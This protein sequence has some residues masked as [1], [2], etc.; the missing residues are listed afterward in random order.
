MEMNQ[1]KIHDDLLKRCFPLS[2]KAKKLEKEPYNNSLISRMIP[3]LMK[4]SSPGQADSAIEELPSLEM[5]NELCEKVLQQGRQCDVKVLKDLLIQCHQFR[6]SKSFKA[7]LASVPN[8]S[9]LFKTIQKLGR[10]RVAN[11]AIID[12]VRARPYQFFHVDV[13][14]VPKISFHEINVNI[15]P[16]ADLLGYLRSILSTWRI[17]TLSKDTFGK[18]GKKFREK[19]VEPPAVHAEMQLVKFYEENPQIPQPTIMG[20]SKK[21]CYLCGAFLRIQ[22]VFSVQRTSQKLDNQWTMPNIKC[23]NAENAVTYNNSLEKMTVELE[24]SLRTTV[25]LGPNKR[26]MRE[27]SHNLLTFA[28]PK[29]LVP[30]NSGAVTVLTTPK[31]KDIDE[32]SELFEPTPPPTLPSIFLQR[33]NA[34]G[35]FGNFSL[36]HFVRPNYGPN[37][38]SP[39]PSL[40]HYQFSPHGSLREAFRQHRARLNTQQEN[41]PGNGL[42]S[43]RP[44]EH[45]SSNNLLHPT[46]PSDPLTPPPEPESEVEYSEDEWYREDYNFDGYKFDDL[47]SLLDREEYMSRITQNIHLASH[48]DGHTTAAPSSLD[49]PETTSYHGTTTTSAYTYSRSGARPDSLTIPN[50]SLLDVYAPP[51]PQ[52][53]QDEKDQDSLQPPNSPLLPAASNRFTVLEN[54][55]APTPPPVQSR[56]HRRSRHPISTSVTTSS[57]SPLPSWE[58]YDQDQDYTR[59][60]SRSSHTVYSQ[61]ESQ[62]ENLKGGQVGASSQDQFEN[63]QSS[64][65]RRSD[66][67]NDNGVTLLEAEVDSVIQSIKASTSEQRPLKRKKTSPDT[68]TFVL[69]TKSEISSDG[70]GS[71][72]VPEQ[73]G[74]DEQQTYITLEVDEELLRAKP[75]TRRRR[76][77]ADEKRKERERDDEALSRS[78]CSTSIHPPSSSLLKTHPSSNSAS[79]AGHKDIKHQSG[80]WLA[81]SFDEIPTVTPLPKSMLS[82]LPKLSPSPLSPSAWLASSYSSKQGH[83]QRQRHTSPPH[84]PSPSSPLNPSAATQHLPSTGPRK[85]KKRNCSYPSSRSQAQAHEKTQSQPQSKLKRKKQPPPPITITNHSSATTTR[86]NGSLHTRSRIPMTTTRRPSILSSPSIPPSPTRTPKRVNFESEIDITSYTSTS[87]SRSNSKPTRATSNPNSKPTTKDRSWYPH[88]HDHYHHNTPL[89]RT[90]SLLNNESSETREG[91][92]HEGGGG[93]KLTAQL[94]PTRTR[95]EIAYAESAFS[96][97]A[98]PHPPAS[99]TLSS[100]STSA[101]TS[102]KPP[103]PSALTSAYTHTHAHTQLSQRERKLRRTSTSST[104]ITSSNGGGKEAHGVVFR[105]DYLT[106]ETTGEQVLV[107]DIDFRRAVLRLRVYWGG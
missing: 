98:H 103:A 7:F 12:A 86:N 6:R 59:T 105:V 49:Y 38:P 90:R 63:K 96:P 106:E 62:T 73:S 23:R 37:I 31:E 45:I 24:D 40:R 17:K 13:Q 15:Y 14:A 47:E 74:G 84:P 28:A 83:R 30:K 65:H 51:S 80:S 69:K 56:R 71:A 78:V 57:P 11:Q 52:Q 97:P 27:I 3:T 34:Y 16:D 20:C 67:Y 25:N 26:T 92:T 46:I 104:S 61:N 29:G 66:D 93:F 99:S 4:Y 53:S 107:L 81:K 91:G 1:A 101:S 9:L 87:A 50:F 21:S 55:L 35:N 76:G 70:S 48:N 5:F 102:T 72:G 39:P 89:S 88:L 54:A 75:R 58:H 2:K 19:C 22:G 60:H 32:L 82:T 85:L 41:S 95:S 36:D 18:M 77:G 42:L 44:G 94:L 79:K 33:E 64:K 8:G 43:H 68:K 100:A 10:Y